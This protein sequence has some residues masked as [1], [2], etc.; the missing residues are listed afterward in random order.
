M[1]IFTPPITPA[2]TAALT[3]E[4]TAAVQ[5]RDADQIA[6]FIIQTSNNLLNAMLRDSLT[7]ST[8]LWSAPVKPTDSTVV[9][10]LASLQKKS[11]AKGDTTEVLFNGHKGMLAYLESQHP[12][13]TATITAL[14][15]A[16]TFGADGSVILEK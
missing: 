2:Q 5:A 11:V 15:P 10:R 12:G 1:P 14:I 16:F 3:P 7:G 4:Q 8:K 6:D 9:Q 13:C